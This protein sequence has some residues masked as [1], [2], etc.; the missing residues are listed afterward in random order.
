MRKDHIPKQF[1]DVTDID[2]EALVFNFSA[3]FEG[4]VKQKCFNKPI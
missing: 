2:I 3:A 4:F 1:L